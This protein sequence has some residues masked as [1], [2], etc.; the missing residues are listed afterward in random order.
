MPGPCPKSVLTGQRLLSLES[1]EMEFSEKS[2]SGSSDLEHD[3]LTSQPQT[4]PTP[5]LCQVR[6]A[7]AYG[8][9]RKFY[10][11]YSIFC[12]VF[13]W[14]CW[15]LVTAWGSNSLT[16]DRTRAPCVGSMESQP[17]DFAKKRSKHLC[18]PFLF[19]WLTKELP[20]DHCYQVTLKLQAVEKREIPTF[21]E[22][23]TSVLAMKGNALQCF[24]PSSHLPCCC[25]C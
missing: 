14:L 8:L 10:F 25:C 19:L 6:P 20:R 3:H 1:L 5:G 13:I 12:F 4:P 18:L 2:L 24:L 15:V 9:G 21:L 11:P 17:L 16:R 22:S 23:I 7:V